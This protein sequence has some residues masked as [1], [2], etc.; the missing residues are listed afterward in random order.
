VP[1]RAI[2]AA[3]GTGRP[4]PH[5]ARR[6]P[7]VP[8]IVVPL[9]IVMFIVPCASVAHEHAP[10]PSVK[11]AAVRAPAH[12]RHVSRHRPPP[13]P[14]ITDPFTQ[15]GLRSWL[16]K[17]P[18]D[19]T[20]ALRDL[21][22]GRTMVYRPGHA[23]HTA[24]IV[25]V[26]ILA[27]LLHERQ[28][29]GPLDGET[30]EIAAGMIEN[31]DADDATDLWNDEGGASAVQ[32]FDD[33]VGLHDTTAS[34]HWGLMTTTPSD[35]L[36]LLHT[37]LFANPLLTPSSRAY[38]AGLMRHISSFDSW[39]VTAGPDAAHAQVA[40]KNGWLP[41][42]GSWQVN[43]IG[44]VRGSG[45][46]YLIAVMTDG[47]ATEGEGIGTIEHI[48]RAVWADLA[49]HRRPRPIVRAGRSRRTKG[50]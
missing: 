4:R 42:D 39:G 29:Q 41:Y 14:H 45:R 43:S 47:S 32:D 5:H 36:T 33:A 23:E 17:R 18:G 34:V 35:Q 30:K 25:K 49:L 8:A 20:A 46:H 22:T 9:A 1:W 11:R 26:D 48:S 13:R 38:I 44:D 10:Q 27:T 28:A 40:F 3:G 15:T 24:S 21:H 19:I 16:A 7:L 12:R 37:A 6:W 50:R 31:S 2:A